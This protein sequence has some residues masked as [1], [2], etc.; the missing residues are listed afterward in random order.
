MSG[1]LSVRQ[2]SKSEVVSEV[3][4]EELFKAL[5]K[6]PESTVFRD[7]INNRNDHSHNI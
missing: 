4:G 6:N 3:T 2:V 5:S 7:M 1:S